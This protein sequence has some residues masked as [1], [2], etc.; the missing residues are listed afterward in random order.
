MT[1]WSV[2]IGGLTAAEQELRSYSARLKSISGSVSRIESGLR[3]NCPS[4]P[5]QTLLRGYAL[6]LAHYAGC[7]S[8]LA[9]GLREIGQQYSITE[10]NLCGLC[11]ITD[12]VPIPPQH[13]EAP[14]ILE[15]LLESLLSI[16]DYR[17]L[18]TKASPVTSVIALWAYL[19]DGREA[20]FEV[21]DT[22]FNGMQ[23]TL[24]VLEDGADAKWWHF[25]GGKILSQTDLDEK[26]IASQLDALF[27]GTRASDWMDR[28]GKAVTVVREIFENFEEWQAGGMDLERFL[29][30]TLV[31]SAVNIGVD[32]AATAAAAK[33]VAAAGLALGAAPTAVAVGVSAVVI[34]WAGNAIVEAV[35]DKPLDEIAS[36]LYCDAKDAVENAFDSVRDLVGEGAQQVREGISSA[37]DAICFW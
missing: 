6:H 2:Q 3:Q 10:Q 7:A 1:D 9:G 36:D 22:F 32:I 20:I 29:D 34:A 24:E 5:G 11:V 26:T 28:C 4:L 8:A 15:R 31:E 18:L 19:P 13:T 27:T 23:G 12:A 14:D 35:F 16:F 30:E 21:L 37:W 33:L 25:L 17:Q